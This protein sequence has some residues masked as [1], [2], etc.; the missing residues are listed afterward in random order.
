MCFQ[1]FWDN[2]SLLIVCGVFFRYSRFH[3]RFIR[4]IS[5]FDHEDTI[6]VVLM[7][8]KKLQDVR[9][10][11]KN[12]FAMLVSPLMSH[13]FWSVGVQ[14][15]NHRFNCIFPSIS[16]LRRQLWKYI[17]CSIINIVGFSLSQYHCSCYFP[18]YY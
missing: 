11:P 17:I 18:D 13:L 4:I 3:G 2:L 12:T 14:F 15:I 8:S 16:T 1:S 7:G 9:Q 6:I 5:K 10:L